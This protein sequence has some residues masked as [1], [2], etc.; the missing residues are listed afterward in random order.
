[1]IRRRASRFVAL[2]WVCVVWFCLFAVDAAIPK[3]TGRDRLDT[4]S[5][6]LFDVFGRKVCSDDYAG[7]PIFL[8]FGACW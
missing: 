2:F 1:M 5:F 8:E 7:V 3:G 6:E 4:L